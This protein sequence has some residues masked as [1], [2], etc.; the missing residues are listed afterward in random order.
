MTDSLNSKGLEKEFQRIRDDHLLA[1]RRTAARV[2]LGQSVMRVFAEDTKK[3][4]LPILAS[5]DID[6]VG[7]MSNGEEFKAWFQTHLSRVAEVIK[8]RNESNSRINPGFKWGHAAKVLNLYIREIVLNSR[9]FDDTTVRRISPWLYAPVDSI[10]IKRLRAV[11]CS[12]P[13][14]AIKDIDSSRNFYWMQDLLGRAAE[15]AHVAR[16]WFDDNWGD[17]Q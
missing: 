9:Y 10:V 17:R 6:S 8:R 1:I 4:L 5:I 12:V 16:V 3:D 15:K 14:R 11:G 7:R 2:V 13:F